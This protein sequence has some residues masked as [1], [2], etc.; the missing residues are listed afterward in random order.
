M[1]LY[2]ITRYLNKIY[3]M[4]KNIKVIKSIDTIKSIAYSFAKIA[5][6]GN[7]SLP[8]ENMGKQNGYSKG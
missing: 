1:G 2:K 5:V 8:L 4:V 3:Y 7:G 6:R